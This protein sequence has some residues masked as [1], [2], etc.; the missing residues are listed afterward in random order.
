MSIDWNTCESTVTTQPVISVIDDNPSVRKALKRL[1]GSAGFDV[2]TF[3]SA[4]DFLDRRPASGCIILDVTMPG[5]TG[6]EL[7]DHLNATGSTEPI[8]FITAYDDESARTR[9]IGAGAVGFLEK[10]FDDVELLEAIQKA[11]EGKG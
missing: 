3:A 2:S 10:P 9:A 7:Q 6:L 5:M 4:K 11:F 1:I 8:I